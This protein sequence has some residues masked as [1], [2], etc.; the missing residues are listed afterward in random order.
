MKHLLRIFFVLSLVGNF[1]CG[2]TGEVVLSSGEKPGTDNSASGNGAGPGVNPGA[3]PGT[4]ST[5][6]GSGT[7]VPPGTGVVTPPVM[8]SMRKTVEINS[9][10]KVDALVVIDNSGSMASEQANMAS[11][12]STFIDQLHGL[13]WQVAVTTT[14]VRTS[15]PD[16]ADGRLLRFGGKVNGTILD[17]SMNIEDVKVAFAQTIQRSEHGD[18]N[19]QAIAATYRAIERSLKARTVANGDHPEF[20]RDDAA[21]SVI[22]VTD[23]DETPFKNSR[24]DRV[25]GLRNKPLNLLDFIEKTWKGNKSFSFHSIIVREGDGDC[26]A[27]D[28]N[29]DFGLVYS[30]LSRLTNGIIGS[31][32]EADYGSQLRIIGKKVQDQIKTIHL[33]CVPAAKSDETQAKITLQNSRGFKFPAFRLEKADL[34][35]EDYLPEGKTLV[36]YVCISSPEPINPGAASISGPV[37]RVAQ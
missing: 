12:F 23:A 4:G 32:C 36:D 1:G 5:T 19:E 30:A 16:A 31:V 2:Q 35:F 6:P 17:A 7:T 9:V 37:S 8:K 3:N 33:D 21:L 10:S 20:I 15:T 29:E 14:D 22:A 34:V 13:D 27:K 18:G 28:G 24:G 25:P 11:R 26:L